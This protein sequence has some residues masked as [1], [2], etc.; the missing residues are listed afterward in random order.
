MAA[1]GAELGP[2]LNQKGV[3][4]SL[5][6]HEARTEYEAEN[7]LTQGGGVVSTTGTLRDNGGQFLRALAL[8]W[9]DLPIQH[10]CHFELDTGSLSILG[11]G[12]NNVELPAILLWNAR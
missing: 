6:A 1:L 3:A 8:R 9:I 5:S 4:K 10:G 2:D 11:Y 12:H 7:R